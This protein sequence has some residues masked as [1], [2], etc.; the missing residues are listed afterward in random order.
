[1]DWAKI[2]APTRYHSISAAFLRNSDRA[3]RYLRVE[4]AVPR[5]G[6]G[7]ERDGKPGAV[8]GTA[9]RRHDANRRSDPYRV[10]AAPRDRRNR[11]GYARKAAPDHDGS[12]SG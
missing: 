10:G 2:C 3:R 8:V 6:R 1:M 5:P 11:P 7:G 9:G 12:A 4:I